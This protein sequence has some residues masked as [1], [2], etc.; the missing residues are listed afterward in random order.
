[1]TSMNLSQKLLNLLSPI[2][3]MLSRISK[4]HPLSAFGPITKA[5]LITKIAGV[6]LVGVLVAVLANLFFEVTMI[7]VGFSAFAHAYLIVDAGIFAEFGI[8]IIGL[9]L[10]F[11]VVSKGCAGKIVVL[12]LLFLLV[13]MIMP[14]L[15]GSFPYGKDN[16]AHVN[17]LGMTLV[18]NETI[19]EDLSREIGGKASGFLSSPISS[20]GHRYV[21]L[22]R[23]GCSTSPPSSLV[24]K[25]ETDLNPVFPILV[26]GNK[27]NGVVEGNI[28]GLG[29]LPLFGDNPVRSHKINSHSF[30]LVALPGHWLEGTAIHGIVRDSTGNLWLF[31]YG[32]DEDDVVHESGVNQLANYPMADKMWARMVG[33]LTNQFS[34]D[35][36]AGCKSISSNT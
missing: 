21:A 10:I 32:L 17:G 14:H 13:G 35:F 33:N 9:G 3:S 34:E 26:H 23:L 4:A 28:I 1:M 15:L 24:A 22:N 18:N 12:G 11:T 31:Q 25:I 30:K 29:I 19:D 16:A 27:G 20:A 8:T 36:S 5:R 7:W 6:T 2:L